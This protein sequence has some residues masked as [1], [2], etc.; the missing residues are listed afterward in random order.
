M[1]T[2]K[3]GAMLWKMSKFPT[4]LRNVWLKPHPTTTVEVGNWP[5]LRK[6]VP[7]SGSFVRVGDAGMGYVSP[8]A[9][10]CRRAQ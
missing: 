9:P 10:S 6:G 2:S 8:R 4:V 3:V 7:P 5:G 1:N